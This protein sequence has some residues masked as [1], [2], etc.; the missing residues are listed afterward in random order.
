LASFEQRRVETS[1]STA[2]SLRG[3]AV[4]PLEKGKEWNLRL[5]RGVM[6]VPRQSR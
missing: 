6:V 4:I 2:A 5:E 3:W 1:S